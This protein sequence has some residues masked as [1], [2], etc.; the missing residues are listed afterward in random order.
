MQKINMTTASPGW[1]IVT[2]AKLL[3]PKPGS[4]RI[5]GDS[6][7]AAM[8]KLMKSYYEY[9]R[10]HWTWSSGSPASTRNGGLLLGKANRAACGAF[11]DNFKFLAAAVLGIR[12]ITSK[13]YSGMF[14]TVPG[15]GPC[16][17]AKWHGNVCT[18]TGSFKSFQCYK[19][20]KHFWV[21]H[22][23]LDYDVCFNTTFS[24]TSFV[25]MK[26]L[27]VDND[28]ETRTGLTEGWLYKLEKPQRWG[29]YLLRVR[30]DGQ[31]GWPEYEFRHEQDLPTKGK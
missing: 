11:R 1:Q 3:P 2:A 12:G 25:W 22:G 24:G 16:I 27:P 26:L 15:A 4:S 31:N 10:K 13:E 9:G 17:D 7:S 23:G 8:R 21:S 19:F 30:P 20:T 6:D 18:E 28:V 14:L 5:F 29:D